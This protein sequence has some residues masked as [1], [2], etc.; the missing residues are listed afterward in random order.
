VFASQPSR[1]ANCSLVL[2]LQKSFN[3]ERVEKIGLLDVRLVVG[4]V[5]GASFQLGLLS[6]ETILRLEIG[7]IV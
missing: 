7:E 2:L 6:V 1:L 5:A 3:H 4:L